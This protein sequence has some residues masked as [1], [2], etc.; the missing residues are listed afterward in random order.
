MSLRWTAAEPG[1]LQYPILDI[2]RAQNWTQFTR[3]WR[4]SPAPARTSCTPIAPAISVITPP[5]EFL[6]G[7]NTA[8]ICPWMDRLRAST[9]MATSRSTSCHRRSIPPSGIVATANQDPFPKRIP[10]PSNILI[11]PTAISRLLIAC[12][13]DPRPAG[14]AWRLARGRFRRRAERDV[15]SPF[16]KFL[17]AQ[18]VEAYRHHRKGKHHSMPRPRCSKTGT[19]R[20]K[21]IPPPRSSNPGFPARAHG[22]VAVAQRRVGRTSTHVPRFTTASIERLLRERPAGW[23]A[24]YDTMLL[25]AFSDAVEEAQRIEGRDPNAGNMALI[26]PLRSAIRSCTRCRG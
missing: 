11:L 26:P 6:C 15:Y 1:L 13:A 3:R 10:C 21:P 24:D 23:F 5:V 12:P 19:G 18:V 17:A 9:G 4:A 20:W 16:D 2:D 25:T 8:A 22:S 14:R 7:G